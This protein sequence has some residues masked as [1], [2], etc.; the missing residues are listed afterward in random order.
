[1]LRVR[2]LSTSLHIMYAC[3]INELLVMAEDMTPTVL[4]RK[5][6]YT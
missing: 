3:E 2:G 1:V 5:G 4:L 6:Y